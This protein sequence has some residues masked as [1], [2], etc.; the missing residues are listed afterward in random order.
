MAV[1]GAEIEDNNFVVFHYWLGFKILTLKGWEWKSGFPEMVMN[2]PA[3]I[4]SEENTSKLRVID[5]SR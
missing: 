2:A 3:G 1:L 4:L 5:L